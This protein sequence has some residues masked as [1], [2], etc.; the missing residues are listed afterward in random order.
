MEGRLCGEVV[1]ALPPHPNFS[2]AHTHT[3]TVSLV[4]VIKA[5]YWLSR[6]VSNDSEFE[7]YSTICGLFVCVCV[8]VCV[9]VM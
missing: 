7:L 5:V 2:H 9:L 1:I 4:N 8:C 6:V 3:P